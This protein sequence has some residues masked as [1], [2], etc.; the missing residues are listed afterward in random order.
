MTKTG[1]DKKLDTILKKYE[2]RPDSL[3]AVLQEVQ[4]KLHYLSED[5]LKRVAE[6]VKVPLVQA[7]SVATFYNA[8]SLKP[9]GK[10]II[11][12]CLGTAC[13]LQNGNQLIEELGSLLDTEMGVPTKDGLFSFEAVRC[14]GCC[15]LAP[16]MMINGKTYGNLT[17]DK[18]KKIIKEY[19]AK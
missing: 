12:V 19:K 13:H 18:L 4:E 14:L 6:R 11:Q 3:I 10:Y 16:A 17:A 2:P 1:T 9:K 15:S 8:F 7:Y 5:A